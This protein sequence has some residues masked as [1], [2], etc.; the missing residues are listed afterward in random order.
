MRKSSGKLNK[1]KKRVLFFLGTSSPPLLPPRARRLR[2]RRL[3]IAPAPAAA[4]LLL[5]LLF[6]FLLLLLFFFIL[7]LLFLLFFF[8]FFASSAAAAA[9]AAPGHRAS[10]PT[11]RVPEP[12]AAGGAQDRPH[13]LRQLGPVPPS[14]AGHGQEGAVAGAA[15]LDEIS[16]DVAAGVGSAK[17]RGPEAGAR[18]G[19]DVDGGDA[20]KGQDATPRGC[21]R[22]NLRQR[23]SRER[24]GV[25]R[26]GGCC[27]EVF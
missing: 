13:G 4:L 11:G 24:R 3:G 9:A 12:L 8:F 19:L 10:N 15:G 5:L 20:W 17:G 22:R 2:R 16:D 7:F 27:F 25:G 18:A 1:A 23:S 14:E 26:R 6:F 21:R